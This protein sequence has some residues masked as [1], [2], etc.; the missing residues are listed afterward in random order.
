M[1][2]NVAMFRRRFAALDHGGRE[3]RALW[4]TLA[5]DV[6]WE[7]EIGGDLDGVYQGR[8]GVR[9]FWQRLS[10]GMGH[11]HIAVEELVD[12]EERVFCAI[13]AVGRGRHSGGV[14]AGGSVFA[15]F[16]M[17]DDLI[18]RGQ[19]FAAREPALDAAGLSE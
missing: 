10:L 15:V 6:V 4:E 18:V 2:E 1:P 13:R 17:R 19:L 11:M 16:T 14:P 8:T 3:A 12:C 7:V 9:R 5:I